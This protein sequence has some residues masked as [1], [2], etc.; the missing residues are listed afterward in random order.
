MR[1]TLG[2]RKHLPFYHIAVFDSRTRRDGAPVERLGFYDPQSKTEPVR[3]DCDRAKHW[4]ETG[5]K[6]SETVVSLL[7][8]A[9]LSSDLWT[10]TRKKASK[11]KVSTALKKAE[12]DKKRSVKTR[13]KA[14][15]A[16]SKARAEKKAKKK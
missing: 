6:P 3:L 9:G 14:R 12:A 7:K 13:K 8:K 4:L 15:T 2:G 10:K 16:N 1:L 5:A 11:P